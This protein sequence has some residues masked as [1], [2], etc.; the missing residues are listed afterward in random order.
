MSRVRQMKKL[1]WLVTSLC[2][3]VP[4]LAAFGILVVCMHFI[5]KFW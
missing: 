4:V 3:A 5:S 1:L 2:I